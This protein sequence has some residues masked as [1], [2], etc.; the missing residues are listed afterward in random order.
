MN[1]IIVDDVMRSKLGDLQF[2]TELQ[3]ES[4]R[5]L[6]YITP[7]VDPSEYAELESPLSEE[8][9]TRREKE[10]G[11]RPLSEILADLEKLN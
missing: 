5:V 2:P 11:G 10:G 6:A 1:R 8:E 9:L 7:A 3:D 4:G